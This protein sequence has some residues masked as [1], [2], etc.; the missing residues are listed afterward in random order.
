[1]R[2]FIPN[3]YHKTI[4]DIDLVKLYELGKRLILTDLDNTLVG[5]D[6]K[7]PTAEIIEFKEKVE[8]IGMKLI[9]ISN[10]N[11][12]RVK[13][14]ASKLGIEY[15]SSAKKPL[16]FCYKRFTKEYKPDQ[17][18]I[19]GDQI[20]TDIFGGNRMNFYTILVE[21]INY[22]NELYRTKINRFIENKIL[23]NLNIKGD[24]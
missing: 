3:E 9:I 14:F 23:R 16:K 7:L 21:V 15:V 8:S 6:I 2:L 19:I 4:H 12:F 17:I 20:M 18:V 5:Y 11:Q 22:N 13:T 24:K 10:N 1:M